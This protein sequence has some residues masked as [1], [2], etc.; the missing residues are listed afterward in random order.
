MITR[1][2]REA[3]RFLSPLLA[4]P[5]VLILIASAVASAAL[6]NRT[7]AMIILAMVGLSLGLD[8]FQTRRSHAAAERLRNVV[9]P[10]ATVYRDGSWSTVPRESVVPGDIARLSAGSLVPADGILVAERDLHVDE[11]ALTGESVPEEKELGTGD[12]RE[13]VFLGTSIVSGTGVLRVERTGSQTAIGRIAGS[14]SSHPPETEFERGLRQFGGLIVRLVALLTGFAMVALIATRRPALESL[15]FALALAV[16]LTPEFLPMITTLT[17]SRG[18]LRMAKYRVIV[19]NLAAIQNFGSMDVLCSDKTGTL[20]SGEMRLERSIG[21][22]GGPSEEALRWAVLNAEFESGIASPLDAALRTARAP[23]EG[24]RKIDEVPFD[25][26]RRI[27]SVVIEREGRRVLVAKGAPESLWMRTEMGSEDRLAQEEIVESL[28][29]EGYRLLAVAVKDVPRQ[30]AYG[31]NDENRL[32]FIGYVGFVDPPLPDAHDTVRRLRTA[33]IE[34]KVITGDGEAV[35][36]HVCAAIGLE[37]GRIL[38]GDEI[39]GMSDEALQA[40]AD[41][42]MV[43]ARIS[44]VLKHRI[45][46]ALKARGHVVGYL[47][48][49]IN[50]A[51]SLHAADVGIS[52]AGA[53][54]VAKDAA[55]IIL[56]DHSLTRLLKAVFE[57]RMGFGNVMK[58]LLMGSSSAFGNVISMAGAAYFLPFLPMLPTQIL[59]NNLLYDVSQVAIPVDHVDETYMRKPKRWDIRQIRSFMLL[60]GPVSSLYDLATFWIL[61][62]VFH[63]GE[64]E[65]HTG[66]FIESLATQTLVIFVIRTQYRPWQSRPSRHLVLSVALVLAFALWLP[67]SPLA[68]MLGFVPLPI[69]FY[70]FSAIAVITYLGLV[71]TLKRRIMGGVV[72]R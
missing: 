72:Q 6:G 45:I 40:A 36:R 54:E 42:T 60:A 41:R 33:G 30:E 10:T 11:A 25:F 32:R 35:A 65:F 23:E 20:T 24:W 17:L 68:A 18:A 69:G 28:G 67:V 29:A 34:L 55:Q 48:D 5:L 71:E 46:L 70:A 14:L 47:G 21:T 19:K 52:F 58:Y 49:G 63:A 4:N 44:P 1:P 56:L 12:D 51:P 62:R 8:G 39:A 53:T 7:N 13:R 26:D 61:L 64:A 31:P 59:L 15:T 38:S 2:D 66:W 27:V 50:D 43:F 57:G 37:P 3:L 22:D 16:G 9:A